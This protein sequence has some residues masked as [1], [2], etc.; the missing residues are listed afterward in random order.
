MFQIQV[1]LIILEENKCKSFFYCSLNLKIF[2]ILAFFCQVLDFCF[3]GVYNT[4]IPTFFYRTQKFLLVFLA[5]QSHNFILFL[6]SKATNYIHQYPL[7]LG[8]TK[9]WFKLFNC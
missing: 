2:S 6:K 9:N 3:K 7:K 5:L 4:K 8:Y 1:T